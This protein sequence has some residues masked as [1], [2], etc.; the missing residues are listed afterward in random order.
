VIRRFDYYK[1]WATVA[2]DQTSKEISKAEL[3]KRMCIRRA[4]GEVYWDLIELYSNV[5]ICRWYLEQGESLFPSIALMARLWL[6]RSLSTAF[7][8]RV[9]SSA[10]AVMSPHRPRTEIERAE[11][12]IILKH[13]AEEM[14]RME[15]DPHS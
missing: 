1:D 9:F 15:R 8:E 3:M 13:N 7:Q 4:D 12:Q 2:R 10:S 14:T 11:M 6:E 5:D